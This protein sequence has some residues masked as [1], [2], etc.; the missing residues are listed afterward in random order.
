[1][2]N[3]K[4]AAP[5]AYSGPK[6]LF[7]LLVLMAKRLIKSLKWRLIFMVLTFVLVFVVHTYLMVVVNDTLRIVENNRVMSMILNLATT[8]LSKLQATGRSINA[9]LFWMMA[10]TVVF[11]TIARLLA[12][13]FKQFFLD[14]AEMFN[15]LL[16]L[17]GEQGRAKAIPYPMIGFALAMLAGIFVLNNAVCLLMAIFLLFEASQRDK[18]FLLLCLT[19]TKSDLQRLFRVKQKKMFNLDHFSIF[20]WGLI[21]GLLL[22][23]LIPPVIFGQKLVSTILKIVIF[24]AILTIFGLNK[25]KKKTAAQIVLFLVIAAGFAFLKKANVMAD[26]T[27]WTESGRNIQGWLRNSGTPTALMLSLSP[28]LLSSLANILGPMFP[29]FMRDLIKNPNMN[30][31]EYIRTHLTP[32]Q[33]A[34]VRDL[35]QQRHAESVEQLIAQNSNMAFIGD[36]LEG[37]YNDVTELGQAYLDFRHTLEVDLPAYLLENPLEALN[38]S[39]QFVQGVG[40]AIGNLGQ[41]ALSVIQ[42]LVRDPAILSETLGLTAAELANDPIGS[43]H[44]VAQALYEMSGLKDIVECTDP[45]KSAVDRAGLYAMGVIKMYGLID[46]AGTVAD[47]SRAGLNRLSTL[48]DDVIKAAGGK[49]GQRMTAEE[50]QRLFYGLERTRLGQKTAGEFVDAIKAGSSGDD[51]MQRIVNI[52]Q[53][54]SAMRALNEAAKH[55]DD[56]ARAIQQYNQRLGQVFDSVDEK[57]RQQIAQ[58][59]GV[60]PQDVKILAPSNTSQSIKIGFDRDVTVRVYG[61][62]LH[63]DDWGDIYRQTL[64]NKTSQYFPTGTT[65]EEIARRLDHALTNKFSPEAYGASESAMRRAVDRQAH[66]LADPEQVGQAITYKGMEHFNEASHLRLTNPMRYEDEVAEGMRQIVKQWDNQVTPAAEYYNASIQTTKL[67]QAVNIM[68]DVRA[69]TPTIEIERALS[70]LG[71]T[72][73]QVALDVGKQFE[74]IVKLGRQ[75]Q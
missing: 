15:H 65:P 20:V 37:V 43:G 33:F 27:G 38:N 42:D 34:A 29:G 16:H 60:N 25:A 31:Y 75:I 49:G 61:H 21:L 45:N 7:Q 48:A 47:V 11:G 2:E 59:L 40:Q 36:F 63:P 12:F 26:D 19:L 64:A 55:N 14:L 71:Y 56:V 23:G 73:E 72:K 57:V 3:A 69:G 5:A 6:T 74:M 46:G 62:D 1:M 53:D 39:S 50:L 58:R 18:S 70:A 24:A 4:T 67:Q 13:G 28:A 10:S 35:T 41:E 54:R 32:E 9:M 30:P 52:Q 8:G 22:S 17:G 66:L 68:Q 51:L 44:K